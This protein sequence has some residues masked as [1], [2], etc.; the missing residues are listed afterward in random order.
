V[1]SF[2]RASQLNLATCHEDI[3]MVL[4]AAIMIVDFSVLCGHRGEGAQNEAFLTGQSE[5]S[6]PNGKHNT[7]P[8][9]AVDI[10]PYPIKWEDTHR[11]AF[12]AGIIMELAR[13]RGIKLR[14][15]G[16]W[17]GDTETIDQSLADFGHF[18]L[19]D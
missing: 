15:G 10:A 9:K 14:W 2:S 18:E 7:L 11:F 3:Q 4:H 17:D 19:I 6:W 12:V 16:D 5:L 8:S 13:V 1:A